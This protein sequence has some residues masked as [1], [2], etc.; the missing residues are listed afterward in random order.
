MLDL[1][2]SMVTRLTQSM[3]GGIDEADLSAPELIHYPT[4]DGRDIPAWLYR[5]EGEG[6][7]PVI[8]SIH[9]G[10]E[11]QE[12]PAYRTPGSTSTC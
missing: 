4:H 6:P 5:P 8:L 2:R 11:A 10:P 1:E 12:R 9:G 7:F 3:L